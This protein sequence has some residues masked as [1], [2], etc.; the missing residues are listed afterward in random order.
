M[1]CATALYLSFIASAFAYRVTSPSE[2]KG[3]T[4]SGPQTLTWER[5]D[6][7]PEN[8]TVVLTNEDRGILP[9][10]E[11]LAALVDG[12]KL[13]LQVNPPSGG[14]PTGESFRVNFV[15]DAEHTD[16]ILAQSSEFDI[17]ESTSTTS[18]GTSSHSSTTKTATGTTTAPTNT[19]GSNANTSPAPSSSDDS[20]STPPGSN[21]ALPSLNIQLRLVSVFALLGLFLA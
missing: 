7:D 4:T 21:A 9:T 17:K 11:F 5:V 2:A 8:F 20:S 3:W 12:T 15:R 14:W 1:R 19:A 13:T 6:T 10:D 16:T 18:S